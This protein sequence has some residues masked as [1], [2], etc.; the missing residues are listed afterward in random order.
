[1]LQKKHIILGIT[2]SIAACKAPALIRALIAEGAEVIVI[3]TPAAKEFVTPLTLATLSRNPVISDFFDHRDGSWHSHVDLGLWAH[4]LLIA[5]ATAASIAKMAHAIA[6]NMLITTYL[7]SKAP[8]FIAPAM[9]RDMFAHPATQRNLDLLRLAGNHIIDPVEGQLASQLT[10]KGRMEDPPRI[11]ARLSSFFSSPPPIDAPSSRHSCEGRNLSNTPVFPSPLPSPIDVIP[12]KAGTCQSSTPP[13]PLPPSSSA[14]LSGKKIL[15][16]AGPTFERIDPVRFI[17]NYSSGKMG[18]ALAQACADKGAHVTLISGPVDLELHHPAI[19]RISVESAQEMYRAATE[20]FPSMDAAL[21]T[22]AVADFR[23]EHPLPHKLHRDTQSSPLTLSLVP[24][25]DIAAALGKLKRPPQILI[26]FA[27]ETSPSPSPSPHS[28]PSLSP[29]P[30]P[31]IDVIPAKAGTCQSPMP[32]SPH[33]VNP[34]TAAGADKL[35]RKN[36]DFIVLNSL[37]DPGAGFRTDT[38]KITI[39]YPDGSLH[40]F[41]LKTKHEVAEDILAHLLPLLPHAKM[42]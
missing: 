7:S 29:P 35:R 23:P 3:L 2:G 6:D 4:A 24:N 17:G 42:D 1:M 15:I 32:L 20:A 36:L 10:G 27:L 39:L 8:V 11:I 34:A 25:P 37:D 41:P 33:A 40:P 14:P 21:L 9:D 22:A 31:S 28:L 12:A 19:H 38:N 5:P 26:G 30:S 16:T 13:P 18:F